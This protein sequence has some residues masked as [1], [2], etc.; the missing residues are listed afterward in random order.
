MTVSERNSV[1]SPA[2]IV[3][4]IE[5]LP[6]TRFHLKA[7]ALVGTA[8]FFDAFDALSIAY[9][10]PVLIPLWKLGLKSV[11]AVISIGYLGQTIGALL[12]GWMAERRG[13]KFSLLISV[14]ILPVFSLLSAL[15]WNYNSLVVFRFC[16][17]IGLGGEVPVAASY[18]NE[19]SKAKGR[20]RFV[21]LYE[22]NFTI[23]LLGAALIGWWIVPHWGWRVMFLIGAAPAFLTLPL[24]SLLPESPRWLAN[25]GRIEEADLVVSE[26]EAE[27]SRGG[28]VE[29]PA[30]ELTAYSPQ[31]KTRLQEFF[32]G[33]YLR[34]TLVIW[35][36]WFSVYIASIS[37]TT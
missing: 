22:L 30:P 36:L 35:V 4:R 14:S 33:I 3:G 13:R 2:Q 37:I 26:I 23:G 29:L 7:R 20:G 11:G 8:T 10:L 25:R 27:A 17:G 19:I 16:Q 1:Q 21:M 18:I 12:L 15:S 32:D 5:R 34:R 9:T 31:S 28:A 6:Q 24:R